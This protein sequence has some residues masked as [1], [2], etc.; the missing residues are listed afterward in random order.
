MIIIGIGSRYLGIDGDKM[1]K[2]DYDRNIF[3][4]FVVYNLWWCFEKYFF[5]MIKEIYMKENDDL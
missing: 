3:I 4:F 5:V 2:Y 1:W